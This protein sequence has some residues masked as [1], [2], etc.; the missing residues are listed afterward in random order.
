[1]ILA[2]DIDAIE[3]RVLAALR[4][5]LKVRARTVQSGMKRAGRRLPREAHRAADVLTLA[6]RDASNPKLARLLDPVSLHSAEQAILRHLEKIDPKEQ[7][8]DMMLSM[9]GAQALNLL[10]VAALVVVLLA[11]RGFL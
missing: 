1:M 3:S 7:R 4:A 5:K 9:A 8:K 10:G 2:A 6:R 11:W